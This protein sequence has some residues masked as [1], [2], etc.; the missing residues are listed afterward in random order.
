MAHRVRVYFA[1]ICDV[2]ASRAYNTLS[3][4]YVC[5]YCCS[6]GLY[7]GDCIAIHA[8]RTMIANPKAAIWLFRFVDL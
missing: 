1:R 6:L 5:V 2:F 3:A 4:G 8:R 7:A